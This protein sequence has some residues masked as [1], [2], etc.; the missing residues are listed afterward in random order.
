MKVTSQILS[1]TSLIPTLQTISKRQPWQENAE[2]LAR[3]AVIP[4]SSAFHPDWARKNVA[5]PEAM[6]PGETPA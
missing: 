3:Q 4:R 2:F 5:I 1:L 6:V